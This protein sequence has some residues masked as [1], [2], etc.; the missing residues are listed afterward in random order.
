MAPSI[1]G[2]SPSS[3]GGISSGMSS[4]IGSTAGNK[5]NGE[6][7]RGGIRVGGVGLQAF[8]A[9]L[10]NIV[11]TSNEAKQRLRALKGAAEGME[12]IAK[13]FIGSGFSSN[14]N[15]SNGIGSNGDRSNGGRSK[16]KISNRNINYCYEVVIG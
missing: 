6:A 10:T 14:G 2:S 4:G 9:K 13:Y 3:V 16:G 5:D 15:R 7:V 1:S 12:E 11:P 8:N